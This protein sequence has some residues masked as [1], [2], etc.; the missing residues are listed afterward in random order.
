MALRTAA[1]PLTPDAEI[2]PALR[3]VRAALPG[4][5]RGKVVSARELVEAHEREERDAPLPTAVPALDRLLA[6]GLPRGGLVEFVGRRTSGR[7]SVVVAALAAAT[8]VGEAAAL[9]DLGDSL[10]PQAAAA[11][12]VDVERLLWIRPRTL[13][14]A[15]AAAEMALGTGFPLVALDLGQPPIPGGRGVEAVWLRLAR[16]AR[17]Q[18]GALLVSSPYRV[19]G[20]AAAAVVAAQRPRA[21]WRSHGQGGH[22]PVLLT[23]LAGRLELEKH[24]G[25]VAGQSEGLAL[26][27]PGVVG[28]LASLEPARTTE[29]PRRRA[30]PEIAPLAAVAGG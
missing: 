17:A 5:M 8:G 3:L 2:R 25:R 28:T 1:L 9:V 6:G 14:Q 29:A 20:T 4:A 19:S 26:G 23:G 10:D 15:L 30:E 21:A 22:G 7:F 27:V 16:A 13:K 18:G 24:R 12:G 11:A